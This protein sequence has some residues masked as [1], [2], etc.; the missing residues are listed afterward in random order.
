MWTWRGHLIRFAH[1][2]AGSR[3]PAKANRGAHHEISLLLAKLVRPLGDA[4]TCEADRSRETGAR[5]EQFDRID[6]LH[7]RMFSILNN[8][9]SSPININALRLLNMSS[10]QDRIEQALKDSNLKNPSALAKKAKVSRATVS[11]WI[12]GPT[13]SIGGENL[14]RVASA[15]GVNAHWLATGEG[16]SYD[17]QPTR[18][19]ERQAAY[20]SSE[21]ANIAV[22][23]EA[24]RDRI[25]EHHHVV[26]A[27]IAQLVAVHILDD[28]KENRIHTAEAIERLIKN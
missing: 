12:H 27:A 15:L 18:T 26:M 21:Q 19:E 17:G 6:F 25:G 11:L 8:Q 23:L 24:L 5:I 20:G 1:G 4:A 2:H 14:T 7:K 9:M 28:N 22:L 10:L 13:Q 16:K 3:N